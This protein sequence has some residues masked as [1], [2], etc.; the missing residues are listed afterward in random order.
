MEHEPKHNVVE[1]YQL[2]RGKVIYLIR[3]GGIGSKY[4]NILKK[5]VES[6]GIEYLY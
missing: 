4:F 2:F 6:K 5:N 3:K 1:S